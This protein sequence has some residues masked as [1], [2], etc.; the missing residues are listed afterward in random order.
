NL[1]LAAL[2]FY[3]LVEALAGFV[4]QPLALAHFLHKLG[5]GEYVLG[6]VVGQALGQP[7]SHVDG[8]VE[9]D[10]IG[11]AQRGR[12]GVAD[13]RAGQALQ[14]ARRVE[15]VRAAEVLPEIVGA[16]LAQQPNR[17][18]ASVARNERALLAELL[19]ALVEALFDIKALYH[20]FNHPVAGG[21]ILEVVVEV[22]G[23]D[24]AHLTLAVQRRWVGHHGGLQGAVHDAVFHRWR[25]QLQAFF[26]FI[27]RQ[28]FRGDV[29]QEHRYSDIGKVAG[30]ARAHH[31]GAEHGN[32][33]D[34][35]FH[36][37]V[38]RTL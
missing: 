16:P 37:K 19:D 31:A 24:A 9:A 13:N 10:H 26:L 12:L 18:A 8:R 17:D 11:G 1:G 38:A 33:L 3:F 14:I 2:A 36:I 27:G 23:R 5:Q 6:F 35:S 29:K 34:Y 7:I 20:H 15:K 4:A 25:V 32:F 30:N 28:F 22:A 21:N